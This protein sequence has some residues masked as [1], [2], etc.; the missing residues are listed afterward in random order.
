[1]QCVIERSAVYR[2]AGITRGVA[3]DQYE[4]V[5]CL[6]WCR[7]RCRTSQG[8]HQVAGGKCWQIPREQVAAVVD[9][10]PDQGVRSYVSNPDGASV[11][12]GQL[13]WAIGMADEQYAYV[14]ALGSVS[15][16]APDTVG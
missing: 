8:S 13:P 15:K 9:G 5:R 3:A 16:G 2:T 10:Q 14:G 12:V 11:T 1:M 6:C 7:H 4:W